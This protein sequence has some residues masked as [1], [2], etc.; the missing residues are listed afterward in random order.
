[1][2]QPTWSSWTY[3]V[4]FKFPDCPQLILYGVTDR[5][6]KG[7]PRSDYLSPVHGVVSMTPEQ[8]VLV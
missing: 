1:M 8:R 2:A 3:N 4:P 6:G 7:D 5:G